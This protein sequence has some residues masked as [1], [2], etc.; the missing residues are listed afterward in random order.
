VNQ[1]SVSAAKFGDRLS[2][3]AY[4]AALARRR[5]DQAKPTSASF[6][7][8]GR[9]DRPSSI[10]ARSRFTKTEISTAPTSTRA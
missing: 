1:S 5:P 9:P 8:S 2:T 7:S 4:L 3:T 6:V 10:V